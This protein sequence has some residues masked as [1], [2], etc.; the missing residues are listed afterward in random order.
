MMF[1]RENFLGII[2]V[3]AVSLSVRGP[4]DFFS[5]SSC[6]EWFRL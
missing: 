1:R 6:P 4:S 3:D 2:A 5:G